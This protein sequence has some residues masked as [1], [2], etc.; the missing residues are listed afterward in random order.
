[1]ISHLKFLQR[2]PVLIRSFF[3]ADTTRYAA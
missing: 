3:Q 2:N 1:V